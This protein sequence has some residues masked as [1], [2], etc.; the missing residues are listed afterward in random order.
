MNT[1]VIT[2]ASSG[3]GAAL[4]TAYAKR[5][6]RV[7]V[8]ARREER[9]RSLADEIEQAGGTAVVLPAD[10]SSESEC[11]RVVDALANETI[12]VLLHNA[13]RGNYAS[14]EDTS[15]DQW[16]SI[17]ALN[18]DAPFFLTRGLLPAMK[19][20]G[21]GH[22]VTVSSTA[23]T[24]GFPYNAAYVAA[25][26][27]VL[28]FTAGLRAELVDTNVYATVVCPAGVITEWGDVTEGGSINELYSK[29]IPR[30]RT[31]AKDRGLSL[32]PLS[33]MM[34]AEDAAQIIIDAVDNGRNNDIFTHDGTQDLA[35]QA[36][37]D[38][39]G[40]EDAHTAL[41]LAMRE[42]YEQQ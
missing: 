30:S 31:I 17:F 20:R 2:G 1:V 18:V 36:V 29:A 26:H 35:V 24:Q 10:L 7:V 16:R 33:R 34:S 32:A 41:W 27:A 22:V 14:V 38:R 39:I 4:A 42:A 25:K 40:L 5:G 12:D 9:L 8:I 13:G 21:E 11:Q 6:A 37:T 19:A 15:T 28:G 3:I 23:G